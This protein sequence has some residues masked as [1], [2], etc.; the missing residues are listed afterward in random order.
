M[1][2]PF[3]VEHPLQAQWQLVVNG[4]DI[5][6]KVNNRLIGLRLTDNAGGAADSLTISLSDHD[7]KLEVPPHNAIIQLSLG[8]QKGKLIDKGQYY[9]N[10]TSYDGPPDKVDIEARSQE[11]KADVLPGK[12][13]KS[14]NGKTLKEII[15]DIASINK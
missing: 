6:A 1:I 4:Q 9:V 2:N 15:T 8:T 3:K 14:W 7:G 13:S 12:R 11:Q 10:A 5:T